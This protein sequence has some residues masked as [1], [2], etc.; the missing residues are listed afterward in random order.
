MIVKPMFQSAPAAL[1]A[2]ALAAALAVAPPAEAAD[3]APGEGV[4]TIATA[5]SFGTLSNKLREAVKANKMGI[6]A[7]AC[8][9]CGAKGRGITIPGNLVVMVYRNDF[10]VRML[11]ASVPAGIEAP[12]RFYLTEGA[13][14]TASLTYRT[15]S[16][17]FAPY[18]SADLDAMAQELDAIWEKIVSDTIN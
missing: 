2:A 3:P 7:Q 13:D 17:T 14:G 11:A 5:H 15:P 8:A 12:L 1:V 18:Q 9:S 10:A 16:V 6:I 4:R